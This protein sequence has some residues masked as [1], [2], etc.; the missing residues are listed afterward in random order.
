MPANLAQLKPVAFIESVGLL[1]PVPRPTSREEVASAPAW[2][3]VCESAHCPPAGMAI[4]AGKAALGA[5]STQ[6]SDIGWVIDCGSGYQGSPGWPVHY[7]IQDG[8]VGNK[9]SAVELRQYCAGGLTSWVV[10]DAMPSVG[11]AIPCTGAD[12]WSWEDRFATSRSMGGEPFSDVSHAAGISPQPGFA[13]I[14]GTTTAS[15]PGQPSPWR[16]RAAYW[17]RTSRDDFRAAYSRAVA[18]R[19]READRAMFHMLTRAGTTALAHAHLSPQHITHCV[20]HSSAS[21]EP[22]RSVA[23]A[24]GLPWDE[25]L[26]QTNLD[27]GYLGVSQ[28]TVLMRLA[29]AGELRAGSIVLLLAAEYQLSVTTVILS[30]VRPPVTSDD[31]FIQTAA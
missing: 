31:G 29:K 21:G 2:R 13:R 14:V 12:N 15:C 27:H 6:P 11:R 10:A 18:G 8:I 30:I 20:A 3:A 9:G 22:H 7:H 26:H 1:L 17:Q 16:T 24:V 4:H 28:I 19:T 25:S 5:G 23:K